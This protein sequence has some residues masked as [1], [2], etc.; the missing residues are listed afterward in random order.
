MSGYLTKSDVARH[1]GCTRVD[2]DRMI[3]EDGLPIVRFP[4]RARPLIKILPA[5][6]YEWEK[7]LSKGGFPSFK[8]WG[9]SLREMLSVKCEVGNTK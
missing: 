2:L 8:V 5:A 7:G 3:L 6:L 1:L 9:G 4:G